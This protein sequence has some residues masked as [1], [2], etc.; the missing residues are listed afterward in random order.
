MHYLSEHLKT[1]DG[2]LSIP[3]WERKVYVGAA[4]VKLSEDQE[5]FVNAAV[6]LVEVAG[7]NASDPA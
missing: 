4:A 3:E 6:E 2:A 5:T 7:A 1:E